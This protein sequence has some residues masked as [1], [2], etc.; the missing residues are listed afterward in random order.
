MKRSLR[1]WA[2]CMAAFVCVAVVSVQAQAGTIISS[3]T[4][5]AG[6]ATAISMGTLEEGVLAYTDRTH[7]L[8]NIPDKLEGAS[9]LVMVSNSDKSSDPY[10]VDVTFGH[11]SI[12][13]IGLDDRFA[14]PFG[15]MDDPG[16]T[17]L[18]TKFFDTGAQIDIDESGDGSI[19]Q[20]FSLW[21]TIA[22]AGTY[23]TFVNGNGG[24][25]Y[26]I[27]GS[28]CLVVPEPGT[29]SLVG[30]GLIGLVGLRRRR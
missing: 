28:D 25:N 11:L 19:D 29:L 22:P 5:V 4:K 15:W 17:G 10:Q 12:M 7:T 21:A 16:Q 6:N 9:D 13:Y 1:T 27:F 30:L 23:S 18:P 3:A 2:A 26:I 14:Q 8:V 24:N 20:T